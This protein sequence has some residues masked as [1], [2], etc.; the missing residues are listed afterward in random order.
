[1]VQK[2]TEPLALSTAEK[3]QDVSSTLRSRSQDALKN[4]QEN[5]S[6]AST[7]VTRQAANVVEQGSKLLERTKDQLPPVNKPDEG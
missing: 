2:D 3:L 1:K 7:A 6:S 5:A 4:A